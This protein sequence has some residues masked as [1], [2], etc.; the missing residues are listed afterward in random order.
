LVNAKIAFLLSESQVTPSKL[1]AYF[2]KKTTVQIAAAIV[3]S[4]SF[5]TLANN[6][7]AQDDFTAFCKIDI[8]LEKLRENALAREAIDN[9]SIAD[10]DMWMFDPDIKLSQIKR[11]EGQF[12]PNMINTVVLFESFFSIPTVNQ[13]RDDDGTVQY[14]IVVRATGEETSTDDENA[15]REAIMKRVSEIE[16]KR[17]SLHKSMQ[18]M[19]PEF[20]LRME[21]NDERSGSLAVTRFFG[22]RMIR[23]TIDGKQCYRFPVTNKAFAISLSADKKVIEISSDKYLF[24]KKEL[25]CT[26]AIENYFKV[27]SDS[28]IRIAFDLKR[29]RWRMER[30]PRLKDLTGI[31]AH[32]INHCRFAGFAMGLNQDKLVSI[33][34]ATPDQKR[35]APLVTRMNEYLQPVIESAPSLA[36]N[37]FATGSGEMRT[38]E[39][40]IEQ[41]KF[42]ADGLNVDLIIHRPEHFVAMTQTV[43]A[44]FKKAADLAM[45]KNRFR[46]IALGIFT[47]N[48]SNKRCPFP[49]PYREG[50]HS[51]VS[52]RVLVLPFCEERAVYGKFKVDQP[53]NSEQNLPLSKRMPTFFGMGETGEKTCVCWIKA[54]EKRIGVS[55]VRDGAS[56]TI[57]FME[58]PEKVIWSK[59]GDLTIDQAVELVRNLPDG[60]VLVVA[61]YDGGVDTISNKMDLKLLRAML[62]VDGGEEVDRSQIK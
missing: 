19:R 18:E 39:Q 43:A 27:N 44:K 30:V 47:F 51:D 49:E 46:L 12:G 61:F 11:I 56:N 2:M 26:E 33:H 36:S 35:V 21:F 13:W 58:N 34:L 1:N 50:I 60:E 42:K 41:C 15:D 10:F 59:P 23:T 22:N 7:D 24:G 28:P 54:T 31:T 29:G 38:F 14:S 9:I 52:W 32:V 17:A 48:D 4:L 53:W 6:C 3:L 57:M 37:L 5:F 8:N 16:K 55:F 25:K 40:L 62:T 45:K 20:Y